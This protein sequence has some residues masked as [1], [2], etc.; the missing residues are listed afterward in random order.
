MP[1]ASCCACDRSENL[2]LLSRVWSRSSTS[3]SLPERST[4]ARSSRLARS[5]SAL[6]SSRPSWMYRMDV[7]AGADASVA[8]PFSRRAP[9]RT[10]MSIRNAGWGGHVAAAAEEPLA[11]DGR[12]G[13]GTRRR[14]TSLRSVGRGGASPSPVA[15]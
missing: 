1:S 13:G 9:Q 8:E 5:S 10:Q 4:R 15:N 3:N 12:A 7:V 6:E 2:A 14:F 11:V